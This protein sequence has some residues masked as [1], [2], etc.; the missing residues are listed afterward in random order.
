M[1][2]TQYSLSTELLSEHMYSAVILQPVILD[3][4]ADNQKDFLFFQQIL[5]NFKQHNPKFNSCDIERYQWRQ[6]NWK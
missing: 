3:L 4:N 5:E 6:Y 1:P 2:F